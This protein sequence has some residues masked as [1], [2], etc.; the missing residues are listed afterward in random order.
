MKDASGKL[1]SGIL[2]QQTQTQ[3]LYYKN[4]SQRIEGAS[5]LDTEILFL[6]TLKTGDLFLEMQATEMQAIILLL[7][8]NS[9]VQYSLQQVTTTDT[10]TSVVTPQIVQIQK[11]RSISEIL[12]R[13]TRGEITPLYLTDATTNA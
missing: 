9:T 1:D 10:W 8:A 13:W 12:S 6:G 3:I 4:G 5:L 11:T 7:C 2:K